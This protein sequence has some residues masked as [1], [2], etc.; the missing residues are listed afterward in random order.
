M[1][2]TL[3]KIGLEVTHLI[4]IKAIHEKHTAKIIF[5]GEN[6]RAFPLQWRARQE[7][8]PSP[9]IFNVILE[10]PATAIRQQKE[11]T[12]IQISK[13]EEK[14]LPFA[15]DMI[16]YRKL[17]KLQQKKLPEAFYTNAV[18]LQDT[19]SAHE[20]LLHFSIPIMKPHYEKLRNQYH[21]QLHPKQ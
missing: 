18:K 21:L 2:K 20:Y 8:P 12:G 19:K 11:I 1:I 5:N 13:E 9:L 4:I 15:D 7:C 3:N 6:P 17:K 10:V 14:F 16:L